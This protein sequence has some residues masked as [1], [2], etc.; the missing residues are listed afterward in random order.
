MRNNTQTSSYE[1]P[2]PLVKEAVSITLFLYDVIAMSISFMLAILTA[3]FLKDV[4]LPGTYNR[5][6]SDYKSI[7]DLIFVWMCPFV[8]FAFFSKGHYTQRIPWWSQ[9][10]HV[11]IICLIAFIMDGFMRFAL[12]MSFSRL[13][14]GLCWVYVFL[15]TLALRQIVYRIVRERGMWRIPTVIIADAQTAIDT[16]YAFAT[17]HYTGYNVKTILIR[18]DED[19][20]FSKDTIPEQFKDIE[21]IREDVIY[22]EYVEKKLDHF[23]VIC[24][25][26]F[27]GSERDTLIRSLTELKALYAIIPRSRASACLKWSHAISSALMLCCCTLKTPSPLQ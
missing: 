23:F 4:V 12:K 9:V 20:T 27:R 7:Y 16:L 8:L 18:E 19:N 10:Q 25:E 22:K 1:R 14:I 15:I 2:T 26:T 5:P 13:M 11:M 24:L 17:D 6:L 3:E 21:I